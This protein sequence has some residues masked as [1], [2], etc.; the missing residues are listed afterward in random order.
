VIDMTSM[1]AE[2]LWQ[3][4]DRMHEELVK[5]GHLTKKPS[6]EL[7]RYK[8]ALYQANGMLIQLDKEPVKLEYP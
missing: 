5:R 6:D 4:A 3:L 7:E 2:E 1:S 8:R